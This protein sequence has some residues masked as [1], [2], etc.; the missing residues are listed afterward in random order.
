MPV[1]R[2]IEPAATQACKGFQINNKQAKALQVVG[3]IYMSTPENR[4]LFASA[5]DP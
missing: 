5:D 1:Q 2:I 4:A 3:G